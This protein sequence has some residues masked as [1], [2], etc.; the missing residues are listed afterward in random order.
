MLQAEVSIIEISFV[1]SLKTGYY[2]Y[3]KILIF[4]SDIVRVLGNLNIKS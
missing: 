2:V 1:K 3:N 4:I